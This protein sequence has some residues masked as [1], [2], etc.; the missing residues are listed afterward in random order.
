MQILL[1][2]YQMEYYKTNKNKKKP[3]KKETKKHIF[4]DKK[5]K[6]EI[7]EEL[8]L[9]E[10]EFSFLLEGIK[11]GWSLILDNIEEA[12]SI[13]T[14]RLNGLLDKNYEEGNKIF[15]IPENPNPNENKIEIDKNFRLICTCDIN[16]I[17]KMSPAFVNRFDVI[18]LEDQ[19]EEIN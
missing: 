4:E 9:K 12:S 6:I 2:K 11:N 14:E 8:N 18:I 10:D 1:K 19:L 15:D 16:K 5:Q 13:V 7:K 17:K 3:V